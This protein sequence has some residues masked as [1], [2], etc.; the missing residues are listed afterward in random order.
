MQL[1]N[2]GNDGEDGH[3]P[4]GSNHIYVTQEEQ[5]AIQR[6]RLFH[7]VVSIMVESNRLLEHLLARNYYF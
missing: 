7:F 1:L 4:P 3:P 2:E 6:V 5:E